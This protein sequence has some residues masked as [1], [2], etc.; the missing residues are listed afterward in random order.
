MNKMYQVVDRTTE[1]PLTPY[2]TF[3]RDVARAKKLQLKQQGLDVVIKA[4]KVQLTNTQ[5]IR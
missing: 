5:T 4:S 3:S 1:Q 2:P